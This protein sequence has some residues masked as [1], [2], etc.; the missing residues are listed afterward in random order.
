M[1]AAPRIKARVLAACLVGLLAAC[2]TVTSVKGFLLGIS[3]TGAETHLTGFIG[4]VAAD[5]PQAQ[6]AWRS[7]SR[8]LHALRL[9]AAAPV[10]ASRPSTT[11]L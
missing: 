3:G 8:F 1:P 11:A 9:A 2:G 7:R 6:S 5:E 4:G 10:W